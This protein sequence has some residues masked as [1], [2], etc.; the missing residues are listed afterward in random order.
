LAQGGGVTSA[1]RDVLAT[2]REL[3]GRADLFRPA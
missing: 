2:A 1:A 3:I